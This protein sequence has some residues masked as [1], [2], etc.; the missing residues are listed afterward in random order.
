MRTIHTQYLVRNRGWTYTRLPIDGLRSTVFH[1]MYIYVDVLLT[2][3]TYTK[4]LIRYIGP[5]PTH[6]IA[7][8]NVWFDHPREI[9]VGL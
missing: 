8:G 6:C 9:R 1:G 3:P 5:S 4:L 7:A 2:S